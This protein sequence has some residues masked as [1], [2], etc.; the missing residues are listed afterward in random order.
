MYNIHIFKAL[1]H[2]A[3]VSCHFRGPLTR[4]AQN[5]TQKR[6][7][8]HS[9]NCVFWEPIKADRGGSLRWVSSWLHLVLDSLL[10]LVMP[11]LSISQRNKLKVRSNLPDGGCRWNF[12][13]RR[14]FIHCEI[15]FN[16]L[17]G[18]S[19]FSCVDSFVAAKIG[20]WL[21]GDRGRLRSCSNSRG[22]KASN[23]ISQNRGHR[24]SDTS[25][26]SLQ[27]EG[28]ILRKNLWAEVWTTGTAV[29]RNWE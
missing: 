19:L 8:M 27:W 12:F 23:L 10:T 13:F 9:V 2:P 5:K 15:Q 22:I 7:D 3:H 16:P 18:D 1:F 20:T 6:E 4:Q 29:H 26:S 24:Q 21:N 14:A 28:K 17:M 11:Y 25:S